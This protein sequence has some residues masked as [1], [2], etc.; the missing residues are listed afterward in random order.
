MSAER[1]YNDWLQGLEQRYKKL[2]DDAGCA[3]DAD[4]AMEIECR[5]D[6]LVA[7]ERE[8]CAKE[9]AR[10]PAAAQA[11]LDA[12]DA[13]NL[14]SLR[15]A[16]LLIGGLKFRKELLEKNN[17]SYREELDA[18]K[19]ENERLLAGLESI[20]RLTRCEVDG[21]PA[22]HAGGSQAWM[23]LQGTNRPLE[24]LHERI[25]RLESVSRVMAGFISALPSHSHMHPED[26]LAEFSAHIEEKPDEQSAVS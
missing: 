3:Y 12:H 24:R 18:L 10:P 11:A 2:F 19:K 4:L 8:R 17:K 13:V 5:E 21:E 16:N 7:D 20:E 23:V 25:A 9:F 15:Q 14:E 26:V 1:D 6:K 22:H